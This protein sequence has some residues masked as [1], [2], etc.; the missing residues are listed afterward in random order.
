MRNALAAEAYRNHHKYYDSH[1]A[2]LEEL[3]ALAV[4]RY[5]A[6]S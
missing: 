3:N 4:G 5:P 1:P 6:G 2:E